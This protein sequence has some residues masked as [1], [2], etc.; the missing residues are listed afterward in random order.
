MKTGDSVTDGQGR[1]WSVGEMLGRGLW[2]SSWLVRDAQ[3]RELTMKIPLT[4]RDLVADLPVPDGL[5]EAS[6]KALLEQAEWMKDGSR[7]WAPRFEGQFERKNGEP[8]L[9]MPRYSSL[10]RRM[11]NGFALSD[12]I[13]LLLKITRWFEETPGAQHGN[14]RPS[15]V[16]LT[17][18]GDPVLSDA[19]TPTLLE[20][21]ERFEAHLPDR[22]SF[23]PREAQ[24][25]V[26]A[27]LGWD[28]WAIS[29]MLYQ[30]AMT[31][32]GPRDSRRDDR[33]HLPKQGL[34]KVELA[35]LKDRVLA[36]LKEDRS[37]P[38]FAPRL[39]ERL[40]QLLNRGL[41]RQHEPSPPYRFENASTL[42]PRLQEVA[43]LIDPRVDHV[44]HLLLASS[45]KNG[46]FQG[47][48]A[49]TFS[50]T[51]GC[52]P[53][54]SGHED[55][56]C[57]LQVTDLD[58]LG[59]EARVPVRDSKYTV[60]P[61]PSGRLRFD[62]NLPELP[63][64]RYRAN[65]AFTIKDGVGE[66]AVA[67]GDFE[68]RPPPGYVPPAEELAPP[69]VVPLAIAK[70]SPDPAPVSEPPRLEVVP[71]PADDAF[72][73]PIAPSSPGSSPG[74][75][76]VP[77]VGSSAK[78]NDTLSGP[79]PVP[80]V[81][82]EQ[83][84]TARPSD[85]DIYDAPAPRVPVAPP[86]MLAIPTPAISPPQMLPE[87]LG[88]NPT[89]PSETPPPNWS[90]PVDWDDVAHDPAGGDAYLPG[91]QGGE[92]LPSWNASASQT[93]HPL[94]SWVEKGI[95]LIRRDVWAAFTIPAI[96][97]LVVILLLILIIRSC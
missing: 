28:T 64:G 42:R 18:R 47:G 85:P 4:K 44:G 36:R 92:D 35:T 25:E 93:G 11:A 56:A 72:P 73:T 8:F 31:L 22:E 53:G 23:L 84:D 14:L 78:D 87:L 82:V 37:N 9:L 76:D 75:S 77:Y 40:S 81:V 80:Q 74:E 46:V 12:A 27:A 43:E 83:E 54:V 21:R 63:P 90:R 88:E 69:S 71:P 48:E 34:D 94:M 41:A 45:A 49:A 96:T 19:A 16:L 91:P 6:R 24:D 2:G 55:V 10:K 15:N 20:W 57:G 89:R 5:L 65:V 51:I 68:I 58:A 1:S 66:P 29:L 79:S 32:P 60:K 7:P 97:V 52:S 95:E 33:I 67:G 39:A 13:E 26:K 61:H 50:V 59:E 70:K 3:G 38:R 30:S 86:P 62:F 17:E